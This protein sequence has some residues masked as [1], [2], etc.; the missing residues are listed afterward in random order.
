MSETL[1]N[2]N[3]MASEDWQKPSGW[4]DIRSGALPNSIYFLV[5][6]SADYLKYPTFEVRASVSSGTYDVF[7]DG[8]KQAT[9]ESAT[10]TELN[11][12]TLN[13]ASGFEVTY[14]EALKTHVVRI[15]PTSSTATLTAIRLQLEKNFGALWMHVN[16]NNAINL[17][18]CFD[19]NCTTLEA[20]TSQGGTLQVLSLYA[21]FQN[22]S[23]LKE[24]PVLD[25]NGQDM[26][27]NGTFA[28]CKNLKKISFKNFYANSQQYRRFTSC[29]KLKKMECI[30]S[31]FTP[32][33]AEFYGCSFLV[34]MPPF[35]PFAENVSSV[36]VENLFAASTNVK[37]TLLDFSIYP[38]FSK[39]TLGGTLNNRLDWVKGLIVSAGALF[40]STTAPQ[41]DVSYTGLN[42]SALVNL[43]N[44]L[45][46]VQN[47]QVCNVTGCTGAAD[48]TADDLAIATNK[49]WTVTR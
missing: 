20:V 37:D 2:Q 21:S 33:T 11:W 28:N 44:S 8:V 45:P 26:S 31:Y 3:Q 49:G 42:K 36:S 47:S 29:A 23:S 30:N 10:Y 15:T 9:T 40:D 7:V 39:L 18:R 32:T 12:Q 19:N 25:C 35:G 43:L 5:G 48:L 16:I 22:C 13:L 27:P 17:T 41:L 24:V 14:P 6:H 4:V 1:I 38:Q 34:E 46:T